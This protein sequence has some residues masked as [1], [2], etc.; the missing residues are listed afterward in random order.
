[1]DGATE[2]QLQVDD[3]ADFSSPGIDLV[4]GWTHWCA[5]GF[6]EG[7]INHWRVRAFEGCGF[8]GPWNSGD[9]FTVHE[10][11]SLPTP[12][13]VTPYQ[14][15]VVRT[16]PGFTWNAGFG[17]TIGLIQINTYE[18]FIAPK[19][20]ATTYGQFITGF[21]LDVS[22]EY[23][24][25]VKTSNACEES[26]WSDV[27][28]FWTEDYQQY[29][30]TFESKTVHRGE[31]NVALRI[32]GTWMFGLA[33]IH[34][35][36]VVR[37]VDGGAFWTGQLPFDSSTIAGGTHGVNWNWVNQDFADQ[38]RAV[39]PGVP[40]FPCDPGA[41][42]G[43]DGNTPDHLY[44]VALQNHSTQTE[45]EHL[46]DWNFLT[47]TFDVNLQ[48]GSF[49]FDTACH[50]ADLIGLRIVDANGFS[51]GSGIFDGSGCFGCKNDCYFTK[52]VVTISECECGAWGDVNGD[53]AVN[54]VDVVFMVNYVYKG[55]DARIQPQDCLY[56]AGD[57]DCSQQVNP[58][59]VVYFVNYVYKNQNAF[60]DP[61]LD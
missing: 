57:A 11:A 43:Y 17:G 24:W 27:R 47:L 13:L 58:V 60:C 41:D 51:H 25:R 53:G 52:G 4:T 20:E 21:L 45:P 1:M 59:D 54:P 12:E 19:F 61:C 40:G 26:D 29:S 44:I 50:N 8:W 22:T 6:T 34:I 36:I 42:I 32:F 56:E 7:S 31:E 14:G 3:N 10:Y 48:A 16:Y 15:Q 49:E 28:S 55:Q 30:V 38:T 37:S 18:S 5:G 39:I 46:D 23:F 33:Y 9:S 35:P 2:Y